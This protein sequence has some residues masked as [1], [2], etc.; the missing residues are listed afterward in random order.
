FNKLYDE[1][2]A[3]IR[4]ALNMLYAEEVQR[5]VR[6]KKTLGG[7]YAPCL[8]IP[9]GSWI[10]GELS[11][12]ITLEPVYRLPI[13]PKSDLGS[14]QAVFGPVGSG[15]TVLLSS[16][17]C[18]SI[19]AKGQTVLI[20]LNDKTN[21]YSLAALPA[22]AY[23]KST[24]RMMQ[25]LKIMDVEPKGVPCISVTVL[26]KGEEVDSIA[27]HPPTIYDRVLEVDDPSN[28][29]VDFDELLSELKS[30]AEDYG[31]SKPVGIIAFRNMLRVDDKRYIDVEAASNVLNE[32]DKWRK[33]NMGIPMRVVIDEISYMAAS[34]ALIYA[35]DKLKAGATISDFIKE[36]RRNAIA[37]DVA[38]QVPIEVL[39]VIRNEATNV[40]F[41]KLSVSKDKTRSP[42]DFL[43]DSIQLKDDMVKPVIRDLNNR[44]ILPKHFWFWYN[45]EN[46]SVDVIRPCPPTFCTFDPKAGKSPREILQRYEQ[47]SEQTILLDSWKN[48]K[49]LKS[50]S[51]TTSKRYSL[52][53]DFHI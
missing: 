21:S 36:S 8:I 31:Y 11:G 4:V 5:R 32:F 35:R 45:R 15:K 23:S 17:I 2:N 16:F 19:L 34:Q 38:T 53:T 24:S 3:Q 49:R 18:Y 27:R 25:T 14:I 52:P 10:S 47:Q 43:L 42:I 37:L 48:V 26:R 20:P 13:F 39:P 7:Y 22:F 30:V 9:R 44:G 28:F 12:E 41:R 33:G 46:Y 29:T 51:K 50:A 1:V 40:F 6:V